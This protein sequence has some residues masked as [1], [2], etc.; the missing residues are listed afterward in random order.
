MAKYISIWQEELEAELVSPEVPPWTTPKPYFVARQRAASYIRQ[1]TSR[2]VQFNYD[3]EVDGE[4]LP[5]ALLLGESNYLDANLS[6][7]SRALFSDL[8]RQL[9][10]NFV[11]EFEKD[12]K[13]IQRGLAL[14]YVSRLVRMSRLDEILDND[15]QE[16]IQ[17][18]LGNN[19]P[20][21]LVDLSRLAGFG[22]REGGRYSNDFGWQ[23]QRISEEL[24]IF[25]KTMV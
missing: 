14:K 13:Y 11:E 20:W 16:R 24:R 21:K 9:L 17:N 4:V 2:E 5:D 6:P 18:S 7:E 8:V 10:Y 12:H 22:S 19:N 25:A 3:D 1:F 23:I 15:L